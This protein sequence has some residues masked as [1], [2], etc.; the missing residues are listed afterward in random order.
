MTI[1]V[2][3]AQSPAEQKYIQTLNFNTMELLRYENGLG[4]WMKNPSGKPFP[5]LNL[6]PVPK[7]GFTTTINRSFRESYVGEIG[8][9]RRA[10]Q[11]V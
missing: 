11:K 9:S 6:R 7:F 1:D 5:E 10:A 3:S 4:E 2:W 8:L